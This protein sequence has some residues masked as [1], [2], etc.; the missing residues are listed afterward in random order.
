[1]LLFFSVVPISLGFRSW[2]MVVDVTALGIIT[3]IA[4]VILICFITASR[5]DLLHAPFEILGPL[6]RLIL[7]ITSVPQKK[8]FFGFRTIMV[9]AGNSMFPYLFG[10]PLVSDKNLAAYLVVS[11]MNLEHPGLPTAISGSS[12]PP[13][14][15]DW[16]YTNFYM[17]SLL[18]SMRIF[19]AFP[20]RFYYK[21]STATEVLSMRIFYAFPIPF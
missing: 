2:S 1:M 13:S 20:T 21:D 9:F 8:R 4:L 14:P 12:F 10:T 18:F 7:L 16:F 5:S 15:I 17:F 6:K 3:N 19:Y 11:D